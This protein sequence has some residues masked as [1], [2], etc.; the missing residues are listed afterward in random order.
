MSSKKTATNVQKAAVVESNAVEAPA[1]IE[2]S[3]DF[4]TIASHM[5]QGIIFTDIPSKDGGTKTVEIPGCNSN[6]KQTGGILLGVGQ[7]VA[8]QLPKEDW[9]NI[10]RL[11]GRERAFQSY[12]G[13]PPC[14][15]EITDPKSIHSNADVKSQRHGLTPEEAEMAIYDFSASEWRSRF[16][17][18]QDE[19]KYPDELIENAY[20]LAV[21]FFPNTE[22]SPY[23]Y[24]PARGVY[25]RQRLIDYAVC[26]LLLLQDQPANQVGRLSSASEG[27]VSTSFD[28][29]KANSVAGEYWLQTKCGQQVWLLLQP[30]ILGG[31]I[32]IQSKYHPWC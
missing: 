27:S 20:D 18:F 26:H 3:K 14:L 30:Y 12:N 10:K 8:I 19:T 17:H 28:L 2:T 6:I 29:P 21:E 1:P 31:R 11:H 25:T 23:P 22:N 9:E 7:S 5:P 4:V 32:Y 13:F 15:M 16:I 24:D